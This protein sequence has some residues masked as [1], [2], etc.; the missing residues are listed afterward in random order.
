MGWDSK[1]VVEISIGYCTTL[2]MESW[3]YALDLP[4]PASQLT[5]SPPSH[6]EITTYLTMAGIW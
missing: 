6:G 2:Y 4:P 1:E 3:L 5:L